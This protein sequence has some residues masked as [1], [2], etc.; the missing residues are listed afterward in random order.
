M[1][2]IVSTPIGN[3]EDITYRAVK[4]IKTCD[5]LLCEDTRRTLKLLRHY[6]LSKKEL[7]VYNDINKK[8]ITSKIIEKL[9]EK[10]KICLVSDSGTPSIND[11]GFYLIRECIREN[12]T[13]SPIPG[14]TSIISALVCSG[15]P[16]DKF[17]YFGFVPKTSG[18]RKKF[19]E[20]IKSK[21]ETAIILE[22]PY[23]IMKTLG[24]MQEIIPK[25][26]I[27]VGR[28]LTKKF[29]EF[30]RGTSEEILT[31]FNNKK[32]KGEFVIIISG[33]TH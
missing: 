18:K 6:N 27:V 17:T 28:E 21:E 25:R 5:I 31:R 33:E 32:P 24:K 4:Q 26:K 2:Y 15:L 1:L 8:R 10:Q 16:T 9:K 11:P 29:E 20:E 23:R 22:S 30:I 12:I 7:I 14:P 13:V 19:I 3:I